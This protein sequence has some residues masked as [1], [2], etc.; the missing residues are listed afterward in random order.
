MPIPACAS[1]TNTTSHA[2]TSTTAVRI[3]VAI[4]E[5]V[6]RM[7]HLARIDVMPAQSA[8]SRAAAQVKRAADSISEAR[9]PSRFHASH[10]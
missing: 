10:L 6:S 8:A 7:P 5:S 1:V 2:K 9:T 3:P 4:S